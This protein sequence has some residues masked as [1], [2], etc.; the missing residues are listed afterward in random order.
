MRRIPRQVAVFAVAA[1]L[2]GVGVGCRSPGP[3][4]AGTLRIGVVD[5]APPLVFRAKG[6]WTGVE[7]EFGRALAARLS[8]TPVFRPYPPDRLQAALLDGQVD[9]LMAGL[10]I[11]EE[12][13]VRM[14]FARPY[15]AVG[16]AALVRSA[17]VSRCNTE[18]K[19]R[20]TQ[21]RAGVVTNS[22]GAAYAIQY[23][24]LAPLTVFPAAAAAVAALRQNQ[25][26][27][28]IHDAPAAWW[29]ALR[30]R[31]ELA[32]AP[33]VFARQEVA[34]AFRRGSVALREAANRALDDWQRDGTLETVLKRWLPVSN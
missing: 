11:T 22:A 28:L 3:A 19:I 14:D 27:L 24:P 1:L 33:P 34:W 25:I 12:R 20:A 6:R 7:A 9:V 17:D 4:A 23:M 21:G 15:L 2:G 5:N 32:I 13:R 29:L 30:Y 10:A 8:L 18:I 16:Q 31:D 26:D